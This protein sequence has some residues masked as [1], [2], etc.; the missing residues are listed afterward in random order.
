MK[1]MPLLIIM[2]ATIRRGSISC[3]EKRD[4]Q[5]AR[6]RRG[7]TVREGPTERGKASYSA[8]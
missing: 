6:R 7:D 2:P 3:R 8:L 5:T 4:S 1:R